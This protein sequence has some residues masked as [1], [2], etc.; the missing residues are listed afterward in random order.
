ME[1][2]IFDCADAMYEKPERGIVN[3]FV[4]V[5]LIDRK[6]RKQGLNV[7]R[8]AVSIWL[9]FIGKKKRK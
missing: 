1:H 9:L 8:C 2:S 6:T 7:Y 3:R 5:T 4:T